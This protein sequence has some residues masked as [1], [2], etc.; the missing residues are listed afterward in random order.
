LLT[1]CCFGFSGIF[2]AAGNQ[3]KVWQNKTILKTH[4]WSLRIFANFLCVFCVNRILS[5]HA[6]TAKVYAKDA[7]KINGDQ[8]T[9]GP[10]DQGTRG[11]GDG[12]CSLLIA[13]CSLLNACCF[14]FR[15]SLPIPIAIGTIGIRYFFPASQ[16]IE[17]PRRNRDQQFRKFMMGLCGSLRIFFAFF[18]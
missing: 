6:K 4:D 18:A 17:N 2:L 10:E 11:P 15:F 16:R 3:V 5:F 7:K 1:A 12:Y 14:G 9:R 13:H 8:G